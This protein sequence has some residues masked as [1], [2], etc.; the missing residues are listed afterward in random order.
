MNYVYEFAG[1]L[2]RK[3]SDLV[4]HPT[5]SWH[6]SGRYTPPRSVEVHELRDIALL[7]PDRPQDYD[8]SAVN[9][10]Q[11]RDPFKCV[12]DWVTIHS[13]SKGHLEVPMHSN[14]LRGLDV[15]LLL[16]LGGGNRD[17]IDEQRVH[18]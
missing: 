8:I 18:K 9:A 1:L 2:M 15:Y 13:S 16:L 6:D 14:I 4:V 17:S 7:E 12:L 11:T 3:S 5:H 10:F